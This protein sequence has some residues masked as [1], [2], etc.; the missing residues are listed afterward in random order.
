[1][2]Q[3]FQTNIIY[4]QK[5]LTFFVRPVQESSGDAGAGKTKKLYI[6]YLYLSILRSPDNQTD[7]LVR[8][9]VV[10]EATTLCRC[11]LRSD[12]RDRP[13]GEIRAGLGH[14]R[15]VAD[16]REGGLEPIRE[17]AFRDDDREAVLSTLTRLLPAVGHRHVLGKAGDETLAER[18]DAD[19]P[20]TVRQLA[21]ADLA[22]ARAA[23]D[24]VLAGPFRASHVVPRLLLAHL[25]FSFFGVGRVNSST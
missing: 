1:M 9:G 2:E 4:T 20:L 7:S 22:T 19:A 8:K 21:N 14:E 11:G 18:F 16:R 6:D 15:V 25:Q 5:S 10:A 23:D 12:E 13:L 17:V 24:L 3:V